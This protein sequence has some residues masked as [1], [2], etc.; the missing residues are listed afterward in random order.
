MGHDAV[1]SE[2]AGPRLPAR[3]VRMLKQAADQLKALA[4]IIRSPQC[5]GLRSSPKRPGSVGPL[6]DVELPQLSETCAAG[7]RQLESSRLGPRQLRPPSSLTR[8]CAC[9]AL[10]TP[11]RKRSPSCANAPTDSPKRSGPS[12]VPSLTKNSPLVVP[13][14]RARWSTAL[15]RNLEEV[16]KVTGRVC[17]R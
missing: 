2:P 6:I 3:A 12:T 13:T 11:A 10:V 5:G 7:R 14:A 1:Q 17:T 16:T 8:S 15:A 9:P 4:A